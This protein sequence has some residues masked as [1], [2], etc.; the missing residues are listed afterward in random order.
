[1][2]NFPTANRICHGASGCAYLLQLFPCYQVIYLDVSVWWSTSSDEG[3][4]R[5]DIERACACGVPRWGIVLKVG[6]LDI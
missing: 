6:D 3:R 5:N 4:V 1:V 2:A